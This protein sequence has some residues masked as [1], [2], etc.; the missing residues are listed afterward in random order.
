MQPS[1]SVSRSSTR[2][3]S[4][5]PQSQP[6]SPAEMNDLQPTHV[7]VIAMLNEADADVRRTYRDK[8]KLLGALREQFWNGI[9]ECKLA[10]RDAATLLRAR[11]HGEWHAFKAWNRHRMYQEDLLNNPELDIVEDLES[12]PLRCAVVEHGF[13]AFTHL[14][15]IFQWPGQG[16]H[17][18]A[19]KKSAPATSRLSKP[20]KP[21]TPA[22]GNYDTPASKSK[23]GRASEKYGKLPEAPP[24][25]LAFPPA[26][27]LITELAAFLPHSVKSW[28]VVDRTCGN[29][30]APAI[31]AKLMNQFRD[32]H[33][34]PIAA[35]SVYRMFKAPMTK[36]AEV[37]PGHKPSWAHWTTGDH[38]KYHNAAHFDPSSVSVAGFRTPA[39][40]KDVSTHAP[41]LFRDLAIGVK[42]FP[43]GDDALDLTPAVQYCVEHPTENW[44]YPT[45]YT[46]L[47]KR[48]GGPN[49]VK[50]AM[51]DAALI[52]RWTS[53]KEAAAIKNTSGRKRDSH[54]RLQ[55]E[56]DSDD[57]LDYDEMDV[58]ETDSEADSEDDQDFE[59]LDKKDPKRK[60]KV[61]DSSDSD[62]DEAPSRKPAAKRNKIAPKPRPS[63]RGR[64]GLRKELAASDIDSDSDSDSDGD[65]YEGPKSHKKKGEESAPV[66]RPARA[67]KT[68]V[69]Y[70][71][72]DL[73]EE[74]EELS[75]AEKPGMA[76]LI[77]RYGMYAKKGAK[78]CADLR[79]EE[80]EE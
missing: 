33:R 58:D 25:N 17:T 22:D 19:P 69:S 44:M 47:I 67:T 57:E 11:L 54:G 55:K 78:K 20:S 60:R 10:Q 36:R 80:E 26:N 56:R 34:G 28:D 9:Q 39:N 27:I 73:V 68:K 46:Q 6:T 79:E 52:K 35:N 24:A 48:L 18:P 51:Q 16:A 65:G 76:D 42:V 77:A 70:K 75:D 74:E 23:I 72:D 31:Y 30:L 53:A 2:T 49:T 8:P 3:A 71:M 64:S 32:M 13:E 5:Q 12:F 14:P 1:R 66:R 59:E 50:P 40:G 43:S 4:Q 45:H 41:V 37:D 38:H 29:G 7:E 63:Q 15:P 21:K 61:T 62:E